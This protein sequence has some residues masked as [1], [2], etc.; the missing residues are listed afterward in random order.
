MGDKTESARADLQT[1][2]T[3][4]QLSSCSAADVHSCGADGAESPRPIALARKSSLIFSLIQ[5]RS[6]TSTAGHLCLPARQLDRR[7]LAWTAILNPDKRKV[8]G[9]TPPLTTSEL[10]R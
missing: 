3:T 6:H 8:G 5:A 9:S 2:A 7:D 4:V 10:P 1:P